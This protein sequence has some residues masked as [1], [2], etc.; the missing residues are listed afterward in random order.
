MKLSTAAAKSS[1]A[2]KSV[3]VSASV[4]GFVRAKMDAMAGAEARRK[5]A[6]VKTIEREVRVRSWRKRVWR[7]VEPGDSVTGFVRSAY[8]KSAGET[9]GTPILV[10]YERH[11]GS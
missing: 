3:R 6:D 8:R 9:L 11:C 4:G 1:G 10:A 5:P 2:S 7:A